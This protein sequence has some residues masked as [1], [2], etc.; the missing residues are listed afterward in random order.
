MATS[1]LKTHQSLIHGLLFGIGF[2]IVVAI[3]F[4]LVAGSYDGPVKVVIVDEEETAAADFRNDLKISGQLFVKEKRSQNQIHILCKLKN[5]GEITW[6]DIEVQA[7]L[8]YKGEYVDEC[9]EY[10]QLLMAGEEDNLKIV[11]GACAI[12][13]LP[14]YDDI[15]LKVAG[16]HS[17][18]R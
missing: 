3:G 8:F 6:N 16:A 9:H 1:G 10:V 18:R 11:C 4:R 2:M 17:D 14:E 5:T 12:N 15:K 13:T 7:E